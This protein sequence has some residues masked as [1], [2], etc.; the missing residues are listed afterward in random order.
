MDVLRALP[1]YR[2]EGTARFETWLYRVTVNR[3]RSRMRRKRLPTADWEEI[4]ERL[5]AIPSHH[6]EGDPEGSYL[7]GERA[8]ALWRAVDQLSDAHR[9]VVLLRY[10]KGFSYTEIAETLKLSEGTV[11]SRLY[12]AHRKL[13]QL[14]PSSG[15]MAAPPESGD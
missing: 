4:E 9:M 13:K 7:R 1:R 8:A 10:Q 11:K 12:H 15:P 14:L 6:P 2:I 3:C 5:E